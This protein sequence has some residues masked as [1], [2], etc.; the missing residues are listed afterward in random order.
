[1]GF[2]KVG[3]GDGWAPGS[4]S[5]EGD[6]VVWIVGDEVEGMRDMFVISNGVKAN[7]A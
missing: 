6:M 4:D 5:E 2:D 3:S 1:M 7:E